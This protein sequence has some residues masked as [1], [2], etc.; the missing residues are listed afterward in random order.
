MSQVTQSCNGCNKL[1]QRAQRQW[2]GGS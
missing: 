2:G 1:L